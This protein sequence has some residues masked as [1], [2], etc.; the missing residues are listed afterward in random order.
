MPITF[1]IPFI[2]VK[3]LVRITRKPT[4]MN[5]VFMG[6]LPTRRAAMGAAIRPPM[7]RPATSNRKNV[8][9][10]I[11]KAIELANTTKNSARQ[12]DPIT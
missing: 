4:E 3:M 6:I 9:R 2:K 11:K 10:Y 5:I 1:E 7:I 12:T 8:F